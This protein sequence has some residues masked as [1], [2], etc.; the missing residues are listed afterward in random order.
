V[1][2]RNHVG[3]IHGKEAPLVAIVRFIDYLCHA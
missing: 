3:K 2:G 1:L